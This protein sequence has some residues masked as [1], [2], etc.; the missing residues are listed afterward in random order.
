M[1]PRRPAQYQMQN[2]NTSIQSNRSY[3]K[4]RMSAEREGVTRAVVG[5][6][7][8]SKSLTFTLMYN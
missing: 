2:K 1:S 4:N 3:D 8:L 6:N 5:V 7:V